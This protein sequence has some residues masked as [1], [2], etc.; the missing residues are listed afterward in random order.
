MS[1]P[2]TVS[3]MSAEELEAYKKKHEN[4]RQKKMDKPADWRW[5]QNRKRDA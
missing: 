5:P 1:A 4:K 3:Y 2:V